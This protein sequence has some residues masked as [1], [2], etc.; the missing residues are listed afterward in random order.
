MNPRVIFQEEICKGCGLCLSV[1]PKEII[2]LASLINR[3]G[4]HPAQVADQEQCISCAFCAIICP[5]SVISVY[6]PAKPKEKKI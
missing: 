4:Y 1:C 5:D 2:S 3:S 6:R